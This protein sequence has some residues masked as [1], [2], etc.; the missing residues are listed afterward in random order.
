MVKN[1]FNTAKNFRENLK[2]IFKTVKNFWA[3]V[4][5]FQGKRKLLKILYV[6]SI[7]TTVKSSRA[8]LF[9]LGQAQVAQKP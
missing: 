5:F 3:I 4:F 9:F 1:M 6:K 2:G 8:T 7:F